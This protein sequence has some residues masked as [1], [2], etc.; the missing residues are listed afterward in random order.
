[1]Y[2][3]E[4]YDIFFPFSEG[5]TRKL[6][7][8]YQKSFTTKYNSHKEVKSLPILSDIVRELQIVAADIFWTEN[9][10]EDQLKEI[11]L[12]LLKVAQYGKYFVDKDSFNFNKFNTTCK[13]IRVIN[14]LRNDEN[15]PI[16]ITYQEYLSMN[17]LDIIDILIKYKNFKS[18]SQICKYLDYESKKV[19]YKFMIEKMKKEL[20]KAENKRLSSD[21]SKEKN[22][23]EE[24]IYQKLL[25]DIE[26]MEDISYVKLAKKANKYGNEKFAMKLLDQ[27]KSALTK[28][29]QLVELKKL[30]NSLNICFETYDFN[31]VSIVLNKI[32][33]NSKLDKTVN[34]KVYM[35]TLCMPELQPHHRKIVLFL[36][37]YRPKKL[38]YYL[39]NTKNYNEYLFMKLDELFK[40]QTL[41]KKK[42][43]F[44]E[45]KKEIKNYD[46]KYKKYI[47]SLENS[48]KFKKSCME[49]NIIH[50][51]EIEPYKKTVYD[52]FLS[53]FKKEKANLIESQNKNFEYGNKKLNI[54]KFRAYLEL[55]RKDAIEN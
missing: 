44:E 13:D 7:K 38:E 2:D 54:M 34:E 28:I 14:Q 33:Q 8:I 17:V 32:S 53:G 16:L 48:V 29:P 31:V 27:E 6:I 55:N 12:F 22:A 47:E 52:C 46:P 26:K 25:N 4:F 40:T 42:K 51:S 10:N 50:Y 36:K 41:E 9:E 21:K 45:I 24:E 49:N 37:K 1:M 35:D 3:E 18:A 20:E 5:D 39:L 43:I 19:M 11:Q 15:C 30:V 23:E